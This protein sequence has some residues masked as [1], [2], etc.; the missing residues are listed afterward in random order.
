VL[1]ELLPVLL[2]LVRVRV[3]NFDRPAVGPL[4]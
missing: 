3:E 4:H 2:V 1:A